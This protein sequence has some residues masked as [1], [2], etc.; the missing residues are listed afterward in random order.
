MFICDPYFYTPDYSTWTITREI[1]R[2]PRVGPERHKRYRKR[3]PVVYR[4]EAFVVPDIH[5]YTF[6]NTAIETEDP[7]LSYWRR[8]CNALL[9][10][11]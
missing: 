7:H 10:R 3:A 4:P 11:P 6:T 8:L 9:G 2:R 1:P 5:D